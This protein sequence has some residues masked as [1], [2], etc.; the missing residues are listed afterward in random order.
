[1]IVNRLLQVVEF[2]FSNHLRL[3]IEKLEC[4]RKEDN[5]ETKE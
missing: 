5:D 4:K 3:I 2:A 1:M